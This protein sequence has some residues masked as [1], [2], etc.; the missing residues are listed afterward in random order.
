M[1]FVSRGGI[2]LAAALDAFAITVAGSC[3]A[4]LGCNVGGFTDC[5]LQRGAAKVFAVDTGY[6][7]LAWK[8]RNDPRVVVR[9][10]CNALHLEPPE[11]SDLCDLVVVDLGWTKQKLALPAAL[12]WLKPT[13]VIV[14]LIKP[15]YEAQLP[16][17]LDEVMAQEICQR[18]LGELPALGL[19]ALGCVVS[20]IRGGA[21]RKL[22]GNVEFLLHARREEPYAPVG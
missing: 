20:P 7:Q 15:H 3:C 22:Q 14:S 5:L 13:G 12:R 4:D 1:D 10:R 17:V 16:G 6:G 8:L 18:V 11:P 2:K 19:K 9:E 21:S